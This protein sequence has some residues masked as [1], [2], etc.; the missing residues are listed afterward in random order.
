MQR[1]KFI[2]QSLKASMVPFIIGGKG[3]NSL[4]KASL[5]PAGVCDYDDRVLIIIH[6]HGANDIINASVPLSQFSTYQAH[7][8]SIHL[9]QN[10]LISLDNSLADAQALGLHPSLQSFK[11]LYDEG[12][13]ALIQRVGYPT[14]NRSHFSSESYWLR[15]SDGVDVGDDEGWVG[16]FLKDRYPLYKG[17]PFVGEP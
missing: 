6:L 17:T 16:R 5:L 7:R 3:L 12:E 13:L 2:G 15:G 10:S 8:P 14:I 1:R 11:D 4:G 9:P